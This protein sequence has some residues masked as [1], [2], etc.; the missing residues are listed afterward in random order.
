MKIITTA[1][2]TVITCASINAQS[3]IGSWNG[4]L[5]IQNQQLKVVF[6]IEE[7]ENG[8]S[9]TMDSPDQGAKGIPVEEITFS[10]ESKTI[11]MK[12]A[13]LQMD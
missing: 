9:V 8:Y 12:S 4:I 6:N 11:T 1:I 2:L 3:I 5:E 7:T 13:A 10:K